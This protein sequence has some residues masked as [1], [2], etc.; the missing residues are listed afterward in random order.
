LR[1][2]RGFFGCGCAALRKYVG[3]RDAIERALDDFTG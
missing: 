3:F 1:D 2:V